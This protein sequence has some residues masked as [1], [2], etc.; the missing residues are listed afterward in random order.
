MA[1]KFSGVH[2]MLATPFNEN[3]ELDL[4]S[5][6]NLMEKAYTSGCEGVVALGVTGEAARLTDAERK[7]VAKEVISNSRGMPVTLGTTAAGTSSTL[8]TA[9]NPGTGRSGGMIRRRHGKPTPIPCSP[10]TT[11][12]GSRGHPHCGAGLP[13]TSGVH[14]AQPSLLDCFRK[15]PLSNT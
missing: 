5:I 11:H 2:W 13:Q 6:G 9:L 4:E 10:I 15:Y 8:L 7:A 3:E 1:D 12:R 14:M